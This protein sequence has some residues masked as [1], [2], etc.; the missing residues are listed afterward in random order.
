M[1]WLSE[2][3]FDLYPPAAS[4]QTFKFKNHPNQKVR[5]P[6]FEVI[7]VSFSQY[8]KMFVKVNGSQPARTK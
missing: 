2:L 5:C 7:V 1:I 8:G 3:L 6:T 4:T